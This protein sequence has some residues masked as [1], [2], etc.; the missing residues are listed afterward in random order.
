MFRLTGADF[1]E[2]DAAYAALFRAGT[3]RAKVLREARALEKEAK[4]ARALEKEAKEA[5]AL[6][7]EAREAAERGEDPRGMEAHSK[8]KAKREEARV[9]R[10]A[11][12]EEWRRDKPQEGVKT[13]V[14]RNALPKMTAAR[15]SECRN[16]WSSSLE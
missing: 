1:P 10:R 11:A 5:R 2:E 3:E 4:E 14:T 12:E 9:I 16:A 15:C 7:K 13:W 6:E 8:A